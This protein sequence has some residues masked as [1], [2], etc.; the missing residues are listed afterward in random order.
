MVVD[1]S[2]AV[3]M[4]PCEWNFRPDHC[5]YASLCKGA[6]KLG[7]GL[8]HGSR[9]V[10]TNNKQPAFR[11]VFRAF[12]D[13][14][15]RKRST[16]L[17]FTLN[18]ENKTNLAPKL[19][20]NGRKYNASHKKRTFNLKGKFATKQATQLYP[21]VRPNNLAIYDNNN[22][23]ERKVNRDGS[24]IA[25]YDYTAEEKTGKYQERQRE[26][27]AN[28]KHIPMTEEDDE[29]DEVSLKERLISPLTIGIFE[30]VNTRCGRFLKAHTKRLTRA[31]YAR[32][33]DL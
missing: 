3:Y 19:V 4:L 24:R 17:K 32:A 11:A 1:S 15:F 7:P 23:G 21:L 5:Q 25:D 9:A 28:A 30:T 29:D 22:K 18:S 26:M 31:L 14:T 27:K 16:R 10:L 8:L 20:I 33:K 2:D 6:N 12:Q 13:F